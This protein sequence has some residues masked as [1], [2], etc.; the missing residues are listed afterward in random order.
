MREKLLLHVCCG[1]CV[2]GSDRALADRYDI[3]GFWS[4]PN[5]QPAKEYRLRL[6]AAK[7]AC[8][9]LGRELVLDP[10]H[11]QASWEE[12]ILRAEVEGRRCEECYRVRLERAC[13]AAVG[14][15]IRTVATTL[16]ISPH[17]DQEV[18]ARV[19][20]E[21]SSRHGLSFLTESF[22]SFFAESRRTAAEWDLYRQ[23]Y[24]GCLKSARERGMEA[25]GDTKVRNHCAADEVLPRADDGPVPG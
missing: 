11:D 25:D 5:I 22:R 2:I 23:R 8:G 16:F 24:C 1:I 20:K 18:L 15:S 12:R 13:V 9:R 14:R 21:V 10:V 4:N 3:V 6:A 19:G 17:Q 7:A